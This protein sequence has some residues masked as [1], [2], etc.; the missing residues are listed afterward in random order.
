MECVAS[1]YRNSLLIELQPTKGAHS[2]DLLDVSL[3]L[4]APLARMERSSSVEDL[5]CILARE[6]RAISGFDRVMVYRFDEDWHGVVLA[7]DVG[8]RLPIAYLGLHFPASD[9]PAQARKLYLLN[10]LRL[11]PD[12]QYS[13]VA[14]VANPRITLPLDLSRSDLRSVS[15]IHIEYLRNIGVREP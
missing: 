7:E 3:S 5:A 10:T 6:I 15:P 4:Q 12:T 13:P 11:I 1:R 2:L 8:D 14:I 9:I